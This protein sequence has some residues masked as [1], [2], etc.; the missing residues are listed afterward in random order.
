MTTI[1]QHKCESCGRITTSVE[2]GKCYTCLESDGG[3]ETR[4]QIEAAKNKWA[5]TADYQ[6]FSGASEQTDIDESFG[7]GVPE[8]VS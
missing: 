7:D 2:N 6:K 8:E 1:P 3:T 4:A 5:S